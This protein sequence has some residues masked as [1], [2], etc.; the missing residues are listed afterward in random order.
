MSLS[1]YHENGTD[2]KKLPGRV[3][4]LLLLAAISCGSMELTGCSAG[5]EGAEEISRTVSETDGAEAQ[6][7]SAV[8]DAVRFDRMLD[9]YEPQKDRYN[10]YFTYKM[11]HPWWDAVAP[12][13]GGCGKAV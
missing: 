8:S 7:R 5:G 12:G 2:R 10:F 13:D 4:V 9:G 11:V 1:E 6:E 3:P